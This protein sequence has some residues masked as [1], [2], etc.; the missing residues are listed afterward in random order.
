MRQFEQLTQLQDLTAVELQL[1][2]EFEPFALRTSAQFDGRIGHRTHAHR[3]ALGPLGHDRRAELAQALDHG[4]G[5]LGLVEQ[6]FVRALIQKVDG[7]QQALSRLALLRQIT[8]GRQGDAQVDRGHTFAPAAGS[9]TRAEFTKRRGPQTQQQAATLRSKFGA[10]HAAGGDF[11]PGFGITG[12]LE[13]SGQ[14]AQ[15][16]VELDAGCDRHLPALRHQLGHAQLRWCQAHQSCARA[17]VVGQQH[18]VSQPRPLQAPARGHEFVLRFLALVFGGAHRVE[19]AK[20]DV[21]ALR[22]DLQGRHRF[23]DFDEACR[24]ALPGNAGVTHQRR[25]C[26]HQIEHRTIAVVLPHHCAQ[27]GRVASRQVLALDQRGQR[28][29]LGFAQAAHAGLLIHRLQGFDAAIGVA[30][31]DPDQAIAQCAV[32]PACRDV[33]TAQCQDGRQR[34]APGILRLADEERRVCEGAC[35]WLAQQR[36]GGGAH[37]LCEPGHL[38]PVEI[39]RHLVGVRPQFDGRSNADPQPGGQQQVVQVLHRMEHVVV[40]LRQQKMVVCL[41]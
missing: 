39:A 2:V 32:A 20:R 3:F 30:T 23:D 36:S 5:V 33:T 8:F 19:Q 41:G 11:M 22:H 31:D 40:R 14:N 29:R 26:N 24:V 12:D 17:A 27:Q 35:T 25:C 37:K 9:Q 38:G 15:C 13:M 1:A 28:H 4:Q 6:P 10:E 21:V 34:L 16:G 18:D 7:L